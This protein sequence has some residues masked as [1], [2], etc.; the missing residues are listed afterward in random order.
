VI[1]GDVF[2]SFFAIP[3]HLTTQEVLRKMH[4]LLTDKGVLMINLA[5]SLEG[6]NS[7]FFQAEYKTLQA[8][9]PQI[10][11]FLTHP[12]GYLSKPQNIIIVASKDPD[13]L[14]KQV[15]LG[16]ASDIQKELLDQLWEK[17]I[18]IDPNTK[19]LTDDFAPVEYYVSKFVSDFAGK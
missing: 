6:K 17:E 16:R 1:Y 10:Y 3:F 4:D 5:S 13:R 7:L 18:V 14:T 11:V 2:F 19:I 12:E 15:L 9:F 8:I